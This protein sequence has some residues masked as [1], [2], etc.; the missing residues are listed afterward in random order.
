MALLLLVFVGSE[1]DCAILCVESV[2]FSFLRLLHV[3]LP[4]NIM[5][6]VCFTKYL[7]VCCLLFVV[8]SSVVVS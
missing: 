1:R 5:V 7:R 8:S 6:F 4:L 3:L 2:Y